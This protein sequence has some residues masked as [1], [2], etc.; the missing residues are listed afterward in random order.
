MS[1]PFGGYPSAAAGEKNSLLVLPSW[2][3]LNPAGAFIKNL[4][5]KPLPQSGSQSD[6]LLEQILDARSHVPG[7]FLGSA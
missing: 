3:D 6:R 7:A 2:R 1:T 5:R 4:Y